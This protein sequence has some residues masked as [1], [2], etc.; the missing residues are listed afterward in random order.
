MSD[1]ASPQPL[2]LVA[3]AAA[4]PPLATAVV[5]PCDP[6]SIAAVVAARDRGL[7]TP[8]LVGP[9][10]K[11]EAGAAEA[12]VSLAGLRTARRISHVF[13]M[14]VPAYDRPLLVTCPL[15]LRHFQRENLWWHK[16][17]GFK[18]CHEGRSSLRSRSSGS[19]ERLRLG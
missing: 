10:S 8:I 14:L 1:S 12:G 13:V 19:S 4:L 9:P 15:K 17:R 5:H 7:I 11:I 6:C 18:R 3:R 2:D 16:P